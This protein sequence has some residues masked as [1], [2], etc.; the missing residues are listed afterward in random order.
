MLS[1]SSSAT[2]SLISSNHGEEEEENDPFAI[3]DEVHQDDT[4]ADVRELLEKLSSQDRSRYASHDDDNHNANKTTTYPD[5]DNNN[6]NE[7]SR[8]QQHIRQPKN[9]AI[10]LPIFAAYTT[11]FGYAV[12]ILCG[13]IRDLFAKIIGQGRYLRDT[14]NS[15]YPSDNLRWYAPLLSSWEN[16]Y[17][18]RLYHRIQDC[19]NRP[20]A[21]NPG[22]Q[23]HVLERVSDDGNKTMTLTTGQGR[24]ARACLNL[25]SYNYLGF[26]DDW[27]VTCGKDVLNSLKDLPISTSSCRNEFGTTKLHREVEQVVARFLHKEDAL[28]LNMGFNTNCTTIPALTSRGDLLISD[29]LNH[30]SIV[31]GARASGAAIRIFRHNDTK[32]LEDILRQAIIMGRPRTRRPWN[33]IMVIVEGIYSME[34]EYCD[35]SNVVKVC[36]KFGAY[37][38]LDEAHSIG[39]MGP[40]GRGCAEYCGVDT[41]DIDIMMGTFTKSFGA[42]GGYI[43]GSKDVISFLRRRCAGSAYHNSLSPA[44]C[45]QVISSFKV[46]M[47]E[48]GTNIGKKKIQALRDNSNYFRMRLQDMGLHVLGHYDSPIMP[49]MLYNPTKIAAFSRE[50]FKR[51]LAVVVVG[52][53]A[54]PILESRARFCISAGHTRKQLDRALEEIEDVADILKLRYK[55]STFG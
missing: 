45:Q 27:K 25:G 49:V 50:C 1:T 30:T 55:S 29:E 53:P 43:A 8:K 15:P 22:A 35:L 11:Y 33:K 5:Y 6:N 16:F 12:L 21:S 31:N 17:T 54:V 48:D 36:K 32:H 52:F 28:A 38:Y 13:H 14:Q 2:S 20:I 26:A 40:S 37:I 3:V 18:R 41:A 42:M 10:E 39:A 46:V 7:S 19:F 34:G 9:H 47:G 24:V 51:G 4:Y 44:V 23:I